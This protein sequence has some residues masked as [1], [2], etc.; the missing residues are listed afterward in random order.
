[1]RV[2]RVVIGLIAGLVLGSALGAINGAVAL[3]V[4]QLGDE[5]FDLPLVVSLQYS[6]RK[7]VE[8]VIPVNDR[9][10]EKRVP[11]A[12]TLRGVDIS[13]DGATLAEFAKS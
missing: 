8:I 10:V 13:K 11:L 5:L 3:R 4:E 9:T 12:G 2:H 1:M 7:P 6:D